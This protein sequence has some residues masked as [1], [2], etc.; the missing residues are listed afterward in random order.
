MEATSRPKWSTRCSPTP[1]SAFRRSPAP[2][3]GSRRPL[4]STSTAVV[5]SRRTRKAATAP[6]ASTT[7]TIAATTH[8]TRRCR[9]TGLGSTEV[10][11]CPLVMTTRFCSLRPRNAA[12]GVDDCKECYRRTS[13]RERRLRAAAYDEPSWGTTPSW[14]LGFAGVTRTHSWL[15]STA[16]TRR[17]FDSPTRSCPVARSPRKSSRRRGSVSC[18]A[19]IASRVDRRSRPGCSASSST[20][21]AAL[22]SAS[23]ATR[24]R[25][26][27]IRRWRQRGSPPMAT[28]PIPR[29]P[30]PTMCS[31]ASSRPMPWRRSPEVSTTCRTLSDRSCCLRDIEG[32]AAEDACALLGVTDGNQR[33]LL[34]RGR[35][36]LRHRLEQ[37]LGRD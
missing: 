27:R 33:V 32:L 1:S 13:A 31:N 16:I 29:R 7:S 8:H 2:R 5:D 14:S 34:H 23:A 21:L 10:L 24:S 4:P 19:S 36:R 25:S 37:E 20:G 11:S 26:E 12:T 18:A 6:V 28:G 22:E 35:S 15:S 17:C 3:D 30:G 9:F